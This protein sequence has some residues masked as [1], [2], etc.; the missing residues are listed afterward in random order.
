MWIFRFA[1]S[2]KS[3]PIYT[4]KRIHKKILAEKSQQNKRSFQ[5]NIKGMVVTQN[6]ATADQF[7]YF[8]ENLIKK[9][10]RWLYVQYELDK[11]PGSF[12][13]HG[14][15]ASEQNYSSIMKRLGKGYCAHPTREQRDL[16]ERTLLHQSNLN[17]RL[18]KGTRELNSHHSNATNQMLLDAS[19]RI[20]TLNIKEFNLFEVEHQQKSVYFLREE[21]GSS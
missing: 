3:S 12:G 7:S 16:M 14:S 18:L 4:K 11:I 20:E 17:D 13:R 19:A 8:Y 21:W 2:E 1:L 6:K 10:T 9:R 15:S 5:A